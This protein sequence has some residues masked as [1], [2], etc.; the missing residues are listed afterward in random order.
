VV[1]MPDQQQEKAI[2]NEDEDKSNNIIYSNNYTGLL[3]SSS[4]L[5]GPIFHYLLDTVLNDPSASVRLSALR[6]WDSW[7]SRV[8]SILTANNII[9]TAAS[10]YDGTCTTAH[11]MTVVLEILRRNSE[12]Y[13]FE[14]IVRSLKQLLI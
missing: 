2:N 5:F 12:V 3:I 14:T 11:D 9:T 6:G 10:T 7:M 13:Y 8:L 4:L 1:E